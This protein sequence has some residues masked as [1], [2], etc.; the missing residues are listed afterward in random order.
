[1]YITLT[2]GTPLTLGSAFIAGIIVVSCSATSDISDN[3]P[4]S[5][6]VNSFPS[7]ADV[8]HDSLGETGSLFSKS[9]LFCKTTT[10]ITAV[11]SH[12]K[13]QCSIRNILLSIKTITISY[14][15]TS[16]QQ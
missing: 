9:M 4:A 5:I 10:L 2:T 1:M 14:K 15:F 12:D 7:I 3:L 8:T 13:N 16:L 6:P 11:P